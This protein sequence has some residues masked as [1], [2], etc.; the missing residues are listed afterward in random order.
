MKGVKN[1]GGRLNAVSWRSLPEIE[2]TPRL[3]EAW[4]PSWVLGNFHIFIIFL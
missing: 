2:K 4:P 1:A 3:E